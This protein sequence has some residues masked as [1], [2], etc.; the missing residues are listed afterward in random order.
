[1]PTFLYKPEGALP[2]CKLGICKDFRIGGNGGP[3]FE[4]QGQGV[5]LHILC[6]LPSMCSSGST[7]KEIFHKEHKRK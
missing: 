3:M 4:F 6:C 7:F 2:I 1:M 5:K